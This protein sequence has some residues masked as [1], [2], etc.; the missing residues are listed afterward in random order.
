MTRQVDI[1]L[2]IGVQFVTNCSIL[3]KKMINYTKGVFQIK[4]QNGHNIIF[5]Q[6]IRTYVSFGKTIVGHL[7]LI[8]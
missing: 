3:Q 2:T 1:F 5:K 7:S 8:K 4:I 6:H